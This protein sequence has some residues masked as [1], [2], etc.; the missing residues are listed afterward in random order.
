MSGLRQGAPRHRV[1]WTPFERLTIILGIIQTIIAIVVPAVLAL[2]VYQ[3][4]DPVLKE[5]QYR[6]V[7]VLDEDVTVYEADPN[8]RDYEFR[9][10]NIGQLKLD[11]VSLVFIEASKAVTIPQEIC[12]RPSDDTRDK[13]DSPKDC[14]TISPGEYIG[15]FKLTPATKG[16]FGKID[17]GSL[18][19]QKYVDITFVQV[20]LTKNLDPDQPGLI[21]AVSSDAGPA[22]ARCVSVSQ[23]DKDGWTAGSTCE[24]SRG[25]SSD[26]K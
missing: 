8:R 22:A 6:K 9:I 20:Q 26:F 12:D 3:W 17:I 11:N 14:I 2:V 21:A 16:S 5:Q 4:L 1:P 23:T 24:D 15:A 13:D 25:L 10:G 18:D 19:S 7:P